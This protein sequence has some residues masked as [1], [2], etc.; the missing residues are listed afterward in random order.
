MNTRKVCSMAKQ[1]FLYV[2]LGYKI[3]SYCEKHDISYK[4]LSIYVDCSESHLHRLAHAEVKNPE[5]GILLRVCDC[6][7]EDIRTFFKPESEGF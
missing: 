1:H 4:E 2:L 5:L 7:N 6:I 3:R